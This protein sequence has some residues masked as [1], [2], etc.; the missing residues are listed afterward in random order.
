MLLTS[1]DGPDAVAQAGREGENG[2]VLGVFL[3]GDLVGEND[4]DDDIQAGTAQPLD[5]AAQQ[6]DGERTGRGRRT[7]RTPDHHGN[8]GQLDGPVPA[9]DVRHLAPERDEGGGR[10]I[11][12]GD[13]PIELR[14]LAKKDISA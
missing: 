9:E 7:Q 4:A 2:P 6:E 1:D 10:Q 12:G 8:D 14:D 13:D 11:E 3:Q 5:T